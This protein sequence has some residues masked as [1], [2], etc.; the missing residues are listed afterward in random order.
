[1][2][3]L[4]GEAVNNLGD[5]FNKLKPEL[6]KFPLAYSLQYSLKDGYTL[7]VNEDYLVES[8]PIKWSKNPY[9]SKPHVKIRD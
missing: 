1:M 6:D 8:D 9:A 4:W 5:H 7:V 3:K 2:E